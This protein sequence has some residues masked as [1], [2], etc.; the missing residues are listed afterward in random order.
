M[1]FSVKPI[2]SEIAAEPARAILCSLHNLEPINGTWSADAQT[3]MTEI[4]GNNQVHLIRYMASNRRDEPLMVD[5]IRHF[6]SQSISVRDALLA[7]LL[8]AEPKRFGQDTDYHY[9]KA[10]DQKVCLMV[11]SFRPNIRFANMIF[12]SLQ[13]LLTT[14]DTRG[15]IKCVL[16]DNETVHGDVRAVDSPLEFYVTD[17]RFKE[18]RIYCIKCLFN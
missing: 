17:V 3:I 11:G 9:R 14:R 4:V 7:I 15:F 18:Y 13:N 5:L 10:N 8:G 6:D 16:G 1:Y 2:P 12:F